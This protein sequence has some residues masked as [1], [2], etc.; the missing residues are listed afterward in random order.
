MGE[1]Y[2]N[3]SCLNELEITLGVN[4]GNKKGNLSHVEL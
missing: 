2:S 1:E 3:F 4:Y